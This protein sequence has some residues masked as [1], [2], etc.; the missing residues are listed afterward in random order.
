MKRSKTYQ[1]I[2]SL[3]KNELQMFTES[4]QD[5]EKRLK[6]L[7]EYL[8]YFKT[9]KKFNFPVFFESYYNKKYSK[10][11]DNVLRNEFRLLNGMLEDFILKLQFNKSKKRNYYFYKKLYLNHLLDRNS[12][13]L[14]EK[15]LLRVFKRIDDKEDYFDFYPFF[16]LWT[17][18]QNKKFS[19]SKQYFKESKDFYHQGI[20]KWFKEVSFKTRKLELFISFIERTNKQIGEDFDYTEPVG[21]IEV[22]SIHDSKYIDF[23]NKKIK[24]FKTYDF[25]KLRVLIDSLEILRS[26]NNSRID[27]SV[28]EFSLLQAIGVEYMLHCDNKMAF[29]YLNKVTDL[30]EKIDNSYFVKGLYNLINVEIKL[31][32]YSKAIALYE[33]YYEVIQKSSLADIFKNVIA[34]CYVFINDIENAYKLTTFISSTVSNENNIYARCNIAIIYFL[35]NNIDLALTEL[36]NIYQSISYYHQKNKAY[37]DF[38][39]NFKQYIHL[40]AVS[41]EV[42]NNKAKF[43]M[44]KNDILEHKALSC[45]KYNGD[46]LHNVWLLLEIEQYC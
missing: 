20:L 13:E 4:I 36:N 22:G 18:L 42:K 5:N 32:E 45:E 44:V 34:M 16:E 35:E 17:K 12:L 33:T 8:K 19:Y 6:L 14:F 2:H 7:N 3:T 29:N 24:A 43:Q 21:C 25:E 11:L 26:V 1:L 37:I 15:E 10:S 31:N 27:K 38:V 41:F 23:I 9:H 28:E 40:L 46:S 30:Y 39:T